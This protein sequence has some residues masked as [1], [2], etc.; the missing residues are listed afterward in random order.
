M[1]KYHTLLPLI[2][3]LSAHLAL[4]STLSDLAKPCVL[5]EVAEYSLYTTNESAQREVHSDK[6]EVEILV[7]FFRHV[8]GTP[9]LKVQPPPDLQ[10]I[11]LKA[12]HLSQSGQAQPFC[13]PGRWCV[14]SH[15][16]KRFLLFLENSHMA[17]RIAP[18]SAVS[19]NVFL[20]R[21]MMETTDDKELLAWLKGVFKK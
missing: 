8:K 15:N 5:A 16:G 12:R 3:I 4:S 9:I 11:F 7:V 20:P 17:V 21:R 18:A 6:G 19:E 2:T 1:N 10:K 13:G 14:C